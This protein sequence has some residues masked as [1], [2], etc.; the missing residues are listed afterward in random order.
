[1]RNDKQGVAPDDWILAFAT[2]YEQGGTTPPVDM[3]PLDGRDLPEVELKRLCEIILRSL[4]LPAP[5]AEVIQRRP[6]KPRPPSGSP[7]QS[8]HRVT[9]AAWLTR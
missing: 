5:K 3:H 7:R 2:L 6:P 8:H 9:R 4:N 1:M